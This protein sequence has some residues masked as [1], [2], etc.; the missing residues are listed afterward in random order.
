VKHILKAFAEGRDR[1]PKFAWR[2]LPP[3]SH[4]RSPRKH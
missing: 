2:A 4:S 1:P 3:S